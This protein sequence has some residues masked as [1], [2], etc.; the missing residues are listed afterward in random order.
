MKVEK[1]AKVFLF[2]EV[3][4]KWEKNTH[5]MLLFLCN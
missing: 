4:K 1:E 5:I 2:S 3:A